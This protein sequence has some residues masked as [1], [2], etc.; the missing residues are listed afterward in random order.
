MLTLPFTLLVACQPTTYIDLQGPLWDPDGIVSRPDGLYIARP[1]AG[2]AVRLRAGADEPDRIDPGEDRITRL[3][4]G[5]NGSVLAYAERTWCD[6]ERIEAGDPIDD[7]A[8]DDL[9]VSGSLLRIEDGAVTAR[10]QRPPWFGDLQLSP[11]GRFGLAVPSGEAPPQGAG[12]I[13]LNAVRLFDLDAGEAW[14]VS[15]GSGAEQVAWRPDGA[16]GYS[17]AVLLVDD[18]VAVLDLTAPSSQA[19]VT[20]PLALS[21]RSGI[22]ALDLSITAEGGH[23]LVATNTSDLYV[24]DLINPSVNVLALPFTPSR[25]LSDADHD[26]TLLFGGRAVLSVDHDRFDL[27]ELPVDAQVRDALL[28]DAFALTWAPGGDAL[29]RLSLDTL[30]RDAYDLDT[31]VD[32]VRLAPGGDLAVAWQQ[33]AGTF[34][35]VETRDDASGRFE[36]EPYPFAVQ[37]GIEDLA[38]SGEGESLSLLLL[39]DDD[40]DLYRMGWPSLALDRTALDAPATRIGATEDGFYAVHDAPYGAVSLIGADGEVQLFDPIAA[41]DLFNRPTLSTPE[42]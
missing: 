13:T 37:S 34:T 24:L 39:L 25:L 27:V 2:D 33:G 22:T 8:W 21:A 42:D 23:A 19:D 6:D 36:E 11:D 40:R 3:Q 30:A 38:W 5:P 15:V 4:P 28:G 16:G 18:E 26:R 20:F 31:T 10:L 12:I 1:H 9:R 41:D 32:T 7:C 14:D 17:H 35:V 29:F